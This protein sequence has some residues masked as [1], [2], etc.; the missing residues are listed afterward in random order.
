MPSFR[1]PEGDFQVIR[2]I[3]MSDPSGPPDDPKKQLQQHL[4]SL[5]AAGVEGFPHAP[6]P[7]SLMP[8]AEPVAAPPSR[9]VSSSPPA[10]PTTRAPAKPTPAGP[11]AVQA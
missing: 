5:R 4:D 11:Q 7:A 3:A 2:A 8:A 6:L 1:R 9:P 10:A